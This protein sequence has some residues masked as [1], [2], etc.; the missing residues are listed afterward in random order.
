[1][2]KVNKEFDM[3]KSWND[4]ADRLYEH[5]KQLEEPAPMGDIVRNF[6]LYNGAYKR[7]DVEIAV[8]VL[9]NKGM[10]DTSEDFKF[11]AKMPLKTHAVLSCTTGRLMGSI[12]DLYAVGKFFVGRDVYT[13]ELALYLDKI[14]EHVRSVYPD[15]PDSATKDNWKN[16]K[17]SAENKYGE[18]IYF[19]ISMRGVMSDMRSP[20]ETLV[21]VIG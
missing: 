21:E 18:E 13:H 1:M 11:S 2:D 20:I 10:L 5:I 17:A 12:D 15:F 14:S 8:C 9:L 16:V 4:I 19:P 3:K 7:D 6:L